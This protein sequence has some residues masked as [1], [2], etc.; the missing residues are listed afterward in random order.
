MEW[1]VTEPDAQARDL[2][3]AETPWLL[4]TLMAA[5]RILR[6]D[7]YDQIKPHLEEII[8]LLEAVDGKMPVPEG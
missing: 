3:R 1:H 7:A 5:V 8:R 6:R 4:K 2:D